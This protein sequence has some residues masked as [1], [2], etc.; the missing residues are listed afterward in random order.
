MDLTN[1]NMKFLSLLLLASFLFITACDSKDA[2]P[3]DT[4]E[5]NML[6]KTDEDFLA[7]MIPHHQDAVDMSEVIIA[8]SSNEE[9]KT[10]AQKVIDAQSAEIETMEGWA[11]EWF[12]GVDTKGHETMADLNSF[13]GEELDN[14][15]IDQMIEHHQSAIDV[16][17]DIKKYSN[18]D[19]ILELADAI[20]TT[21]S[22]EIDELEGMKN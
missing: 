6:V 21:Q 2:V 1:K 12:G 18:R 19:E 3:E 15:Y 5:D 11:E 20:I 4:A 22:A 16:S 9:L 8:K 7:M 14:M 13:S 17:Q 10:F